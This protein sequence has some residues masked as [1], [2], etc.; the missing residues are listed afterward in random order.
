MHQDIT[1]SLPSHPF[2]KGHGEGTNLIRNVLIAYSRR[3]PQIGYCQ[4]MVRVT[5][6]FL[7]DLT[8]IL[9][10]HCRDTT[11]VHVRRRSVL[12]LVH[13][14]RGHCARLLQ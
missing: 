13:Y 10:H 5:H 1:R 6:F 9:E 11:V 4:S 14:L 3:A 12:A 8:L 2:Y 7:A